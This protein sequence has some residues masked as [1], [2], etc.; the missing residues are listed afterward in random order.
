MVFGLNLRGRRGPRGT[1]LLLSM[2]HPAQRDLDH[3]LTKVARASTPRVT[4]RAE[5]R[6]RGVDVARVRA[7]VTKASLAQRHLIVLATL[8]PDA[9]LVPLFD[10]SVAQVTR[11]V[12]ALGGRDVRVVLVWT[13][14]DQLVEFTYVRQAEN[15]AGAPFTDH[16]KRALEAD[17]SYT[18]FVRSLRA[19]PGVTEVSCYSWE[20]AQE[21]MAA[22]VA[23]ILEPVTRRIPPSAL[24]ELERPATVRGYTSQLGVQVAQAMNRFTDDPEERAMVRS[25]VREQFRARRLGDVTYLEPDDR[26]QLAEQYAADVANIQAAATG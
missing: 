19:L 24:A 5:G 10:R 9:K 22:L 15:G 20:I 17:L 21:Q 18:P 13:P 11:V 23:P 16:H 4:V 7:Q 1:T 26:R 2:P 14:Q 6:L 8:L 3:S 12:E 25:F